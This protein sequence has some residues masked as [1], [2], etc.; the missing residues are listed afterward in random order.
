MIEP[1]KKD[2]GVYSLV[3]KER[4]CSGVKRK[5]IRAFLLEPDEATTKESGE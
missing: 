1:R 3:A 4:V 2:G 5:E